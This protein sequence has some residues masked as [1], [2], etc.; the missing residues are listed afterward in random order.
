VSAITGTRCGAAALQLE[1]GAPGQFG[2]FVEALRVARHQ[3]EQ[4]G[5]RRAQAGEGFEQQ[6][7]LALAGAGGEQHLA[8]ADA[9]A[10]GRRPSASSASGGGVMSNL[11]LP[12]T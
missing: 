11:M 10:E 7:F 6:P 4:D 2:D 5:V 12:V 3:H 9:V 8:R 1:A